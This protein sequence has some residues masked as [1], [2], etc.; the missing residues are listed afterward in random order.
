MSE[1]TQNELQEA[2]EEVENA[3]NELDMQAASDVTRGV[4]ALVVGDHLAAI[5]EVVAAAG[6]NDIA[7][8]TELLTHSEDIAVQS[9]LVAA[10]AEEDLA[11]S[12]KIAAIA[13]QL[14]AVGDLAILMDM[15][16][17]AE[18]LDSKSDELQN[19]AVD[20]MMRFSATR[21]LSQLMGETSEGIA[22][23]GVTEM[24]EGVVRMGVAEGVAARGEELMDA[25]AE[26][27][28]GGLA[29]ME[30][31]DELRNAAAEEAEE[32]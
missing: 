20:T 18:F 8:G 25:G 2:A 7:Q 27:A 4:D 12:M 6:V 1:E 10:L 28:A 26:M 9:A 15:P 21:A 31:A 3:A 17:L 14:E 23:M 24:A 30:A 11:L 29:E 16:T 19:L 32:A 5:S 22:E 13:G